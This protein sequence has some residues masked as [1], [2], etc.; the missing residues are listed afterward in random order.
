VLKDEQ[1]R[2]HN[3][4]VQDSPG[5]VILRGQG[6]LRTAVEGPDGRLYVPVDASPGRI[7]TVDPVL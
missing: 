1:L 3:V 4:N 6:R 2:I 7:I 5:R